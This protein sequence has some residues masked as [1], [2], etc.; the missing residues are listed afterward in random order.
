MT[1]KASPAWW[2]LAARPET[3]EPPRAH[4]FVKMSKEVLVAL[5]DNPKGDSFLAVARVAGIGG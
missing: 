2:T 3:N 1:P 5:P 4:A